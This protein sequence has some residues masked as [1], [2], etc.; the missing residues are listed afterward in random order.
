MT[1]R[2]EE[3]AAAEKRGELAGGLNAIRTLVY[4]QCETNLRAPGSSVEG[5]LIAAAFMCE[6]A[7][8]EHRSELHS[9]LDTMTPEHAEL[10]GGLNGLLINARG[11]VGFLDSRVKGGGS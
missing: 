5:T 9:Y 10:C 6:W 1:T 11:V 7:E 8:T 4:A 3:L 2:D